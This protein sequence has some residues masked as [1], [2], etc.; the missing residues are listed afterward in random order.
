MVRVFTNV[1]FGGRNVF[2]AVMKR[3]PGAPPPP[4]SWSPSHSPA[5]KPPTQ[6]PS[7]WTWT[8][9]MNW[10][11]LT[12]STTAKASS[13]LALCFALHHSDHCLSILQHICPLTSS[14]DLDNI[15]SS[16]ERCPLSFEESSPFCRVLLGCHLLT[17]A[18]VEHS[19]RLQRTH[20][21]RMLCVKSITKKYTI[22]TN[23]KKYIFKSNISI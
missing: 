16:T 7:T 3:A 5:R 4:L 21:W 2:E 13:N 8:N 9:D 18:L 22:K 6:A 1:F 20:D 14:V 12:P 10:L 11:L 17:Q 19:L 23:P 15:Y